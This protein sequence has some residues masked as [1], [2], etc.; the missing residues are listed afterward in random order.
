MEK[1][2]VWAHNFGGPIDHI[3]SHWW[4]LVCSHLAN[5]FFSKFF[6]IDEMCHTKFLSWNTEQ[7]S[8]CVRQQNGSSIQ[9]SFI[10]MV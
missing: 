9:S 5:S 1:L 6:W 4:K 8:K 10:I 3:V 2:G 7:W